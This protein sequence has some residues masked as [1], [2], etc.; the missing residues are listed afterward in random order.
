[1]ATKPI[2]K[3]NWATDNQVDPISEQNNVV[4]PPGTRKQFGFTRLEI[5]P[6]QWVNWL[7]RVL[8]QW[9][10]YFDEITDSLLVRA[11][12]LEEETAG[13][14]LDGEVLKTYQALQS[15]RN[16]ILQ[17]SIDES[18]AWTVVSW[19][20]SLGVFLSLGDDAHQRSRDGSDWTGDTNLPIDRSWADL[21]WIDDFSGRFV[22]VGAPG[23]PSVSQVV[24]SLNGTSFTARDLPSSSFTARKIA[25]S[26]DLSKLVIV[27]NG[28]PG[29]ERIITSTNGGEAWTGVEGADPDPLFSVC[30]SGYL[31][32]FLAFSDESARYIQESS[33]GE[34]W[35]QLTNNLT[36]H[37][38]L[39]VI[40]LDEEEMV[41]SVGIGSNRI[42]FSSD[43]VSW[44]Y[45]TVGGSKSVEHKRIRYSPEHRLLY[46][47]ALDGSDD[48][49][50]CYAF[51]DDINNWKFAPIEN[52]KLFGLDYSPELGLFISSSESGSA[53][54]LVRSL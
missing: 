8:S 36:S 6:R 54:R 39:D 26:P 15:A 9:V 49:N 25:Y 11:G 21:V 45:P 51:I 17:K 34:T 43:G 22:G 18:K 46:T 35:T 23:A 10:D 7:F 37:Q 12:L 48:S 47:V 16:P 33:D 41:I 4:E 52:V 31:E 19:S 24:T 50:I 30:W 5:P 1:M 38:S 32:K 40:S 2:V 29:D 27:C 14:S 53:N 3:P 28:G 20:P 42:A 44:S 13:L